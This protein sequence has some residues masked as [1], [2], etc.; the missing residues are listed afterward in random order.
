[1]FSTDAEVS[2]AFD[3][4]YRREQ[5]IAAVKGLTRKRGKTFINKGLEKANELFTSARGSRN[6]ASKILVLTTDGKSKGDVL[7]PAR[8]LQAKGV[9]IIVVGVGKV[10]RNQLVKIAG[11]KK[12]VFI[13]DTFKGLEPVIAELIPASCPRTRRCAGL[14]VFS[15]KS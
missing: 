5:L 9:R 8:L 1:M 7:P 3:R 12:N 14:N 13:V 11:V 4:Y 6:D 10:D 15:T 2:V